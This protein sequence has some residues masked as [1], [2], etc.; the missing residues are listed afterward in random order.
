MYHGDHTVP[1]HHVVRTA[2]GAIAYA[3]NGATKA[4]V[5][6]VVRRTLVGSLMEDLHRLTTLPTQ[7]ES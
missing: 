3:N 4:E 1:A 2:T 7:K 5:A 6:A